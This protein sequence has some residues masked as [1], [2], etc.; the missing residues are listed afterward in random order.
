MNDITN[1]RPILSLNARYIKL[2]FKDN[3]AQ[4]DL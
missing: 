4:A 2:L 1:Y 3:S